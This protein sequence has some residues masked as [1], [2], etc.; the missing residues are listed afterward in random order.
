[1]KIVFERACY[2][3]VLWIMLIL[4]FSVRREVKVAVNPVSEVLQRIEE[5]L[6][7]AWSNTGYGEIAILSKR[8][9]GCKIDVTIKGSTCFHF[10]IRNEEVESWIDR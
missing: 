9:N 2:K 7:E 5:I 10:V 8:S 3:R 4:M 6:V 1:M